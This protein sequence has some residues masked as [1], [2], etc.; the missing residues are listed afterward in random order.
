[1]DQGGSVEAPILV[2][3]V[4]RSGTTWVA[5]LLALGPG[6][7]LAGREP[8]NPRGRQYG[9]GGTLVG[10]TRLVE[11]TPRQ[12]RAL[13]LAYRGLNPFTFSRYGHRQWAAPLP[14]TR[15]VIKDPFALLSIPAVVRAT[16]AVVV[17]VYRHPGALLASYRRMGWTPDLEELRAVV[18][19][20]PGADGIPAIPAP[21][22]VGPAEEMGVFWSALHLIALAD[23]AGDPVVR[24]RVHIV[25]HH[26][27]AGGGPAAGRTAAEMLGI[28]WN[29]AMGGELARESAG[30]AR[31][32]NLHNLDRSPAE[33]A[34][35]W[36][37]A[38]DPRELDEIGRVSSE[39]L[40]RL[41]S[42]RLRLTPAVDAGP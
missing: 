42:S 23:I 33:V 17:L 35:G 20:L 4:P 11:P 27:L 22:E 37:A 41:E 1:M 2:T 39:A 30:T 32:G 25:A 26:E 34:A 40:S 16:G 7:A 12:V 18:E 5:R 10:W 15:V 8:M 13:R 36:R 29:A 21:G 19:A 3:G 14:R 9:L 6:L 28:G 38:I 24:D 31:A